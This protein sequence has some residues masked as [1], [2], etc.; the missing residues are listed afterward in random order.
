MLRGLYVKINLE[1]EEKKLL[2]KMLIS[3]DINSF[4]QLREEKK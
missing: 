2:K 1:Y 4:F 3:F